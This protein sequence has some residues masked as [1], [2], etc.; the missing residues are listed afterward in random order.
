MEKF[1]HHYRLE[2]PTKSRHDEKV[3]NFDIHSVQ[4][5]L[6]VYVHCYNCPKPK[7]RLADRNVFLF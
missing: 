3:I 2:F 6:R 5:G 4:R 7:Q 1:E